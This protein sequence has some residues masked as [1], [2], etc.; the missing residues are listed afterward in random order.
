M[1]DPSIWNLI[2]QIDLLNPPGGMNECLHADR[3]IQRLEIFPSE[4]SLKLC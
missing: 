1:N 3:P 4:T 2:V